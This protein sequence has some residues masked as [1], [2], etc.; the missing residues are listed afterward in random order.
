[1]TGHAA[2]R[3][4]RLRL[5][6][7][8]LRGEVAALRAERDR[9]EAE[10]QRLEREGAAAPAGASADEPLG[11][12]RLEA[13]MA[14]FSRFEDLVES[15]PDAAFVIDRDKRI[16][17]WN[18]ACEVLTGVERQ[19]L[20]GR[21][22]YAYAEPFWGE[23]RPMLIDLLDLPQPEVEARYKYVRRQ[24]DVIFAESFIPRLR[25]GRGA[26][27][28]GEA[29]ALL[30]R[31]GRRCGA[32]EI[33]RD[34]TEQKEMEQ[35]LR[36]SE[37][38]LSL[39]LNN[40]SDVIFSIAVE[41]GGV[42][43]F[44]SVNRRFL[45]VTGLQER[46][47]VGVLARD[48][49]PA[50]AH[51]LVFGKY[52]E[53]IRSGQP[54][55]WEEV[56]VYPGGRKV[57]QVTV[58]PVYDEHGACTQLVGMVHD[59]TERQ[60][61]E[62][63]IRKLNEDLRREA[64]VLEDRVRVRTAQLAARNQELKDFAYTV[65]H[66]LKAPLRGIAGYANELDRKHR[67]GMGDRAAF[68]LR[69]ILTATS[70]L[71]HLIED[72]LQYS[73][74]DSETLSVTDVDLGELVR[75]ILRDRELAIQE[76]RVEVTLDIPPARIRAWE[77]GLVQVLSNL[78]DNAIKYSRRSTPPRVR[79]A[80][81]P[82]EG[83]WRVTVADNGI[84]FDMK[85]HDR[86]FRLFNRLVRMEDYEGTGAGLAIAKKVLDKQNGRI[87]AEAAPGAGATF[88]VEIPTPRDAS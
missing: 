21:G 24:G 71:D 73:R 34:V 55:R 2:G 30:D 22:D 23:R 61:A 14:L 48:V 60:A 35:A 3:R 18:R 4:D 54:A 49:I 66:D 43:R 39:V 62:E 86:I 65:S 46:Q 51:P 45:E 88:F 11:S 85:Y 27:L 58:V 42:F 8:T 15:L 81:A 6:N 12:A 77:R 16:V 29:K 33:V 68:C 47:I 28:W 59:V 57:G 50:P 38:Q 25:G 37:R 64:E 74:L 83:G 56:S 26:H 17:A 53:A 87:W 82:V 1:M 63:K 79:I 20:L 36:D 31:E 67:A 10:R 44:S 78:V 7:E 5:E 75:A 72:L 70:H 41:R 9:L 76:Q 84:G 52:D 32:V 19:A 13:I 69:Q 80:A 40:V